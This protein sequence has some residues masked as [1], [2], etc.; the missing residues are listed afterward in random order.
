MRTGRWSY[1]LLL[2]AA[3]AAAMTGASAVAAEP[4]TLAT[5][6]GAPVA[7]GTAPT[8]VTLAPATGKTLSARLA[9]VGQDRKVYL[10]AKGLGTD[11][12]PETI[13]QLYLGLPPGTAPSPDGVHYVG[14]LNFFNVVGRGT[15]A[16]PRFLS[17][18]VTGLLKSLQARK[19][20]GDG[21]TVTIVPAGT[22]RAGVRPVIGEIAL[23]AQ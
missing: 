3:V 16:D 14:A 8:T 23:V 4:E 17:F 1:V 15:G 12:P 10:V 13:Y 7:L 18:D 5:S 22:P 21:M 19:A 9:T 2:L 20:L 6:A 11:A